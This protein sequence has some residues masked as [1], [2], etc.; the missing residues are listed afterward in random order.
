MSTARPLRHA[1]G[2]A[3]LEHINKQLDA[4]GVMIEKLGSGAVRLRNG[5]CRITVSEL[6]YIDPRDLADLVRGRS[7]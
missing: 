3:W 2:A 4:A 5:E 6:R 7:N 1:T